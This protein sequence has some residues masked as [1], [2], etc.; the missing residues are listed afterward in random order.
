LLAQWHYLGGEVVARLVTPMESGL[1]T[2]A[3]RR[4]SGTSS[5]SAI[6]ID[7]AS[8]LLLQLNPSTST[9]HGFRVTM[10]GFTDAG[11]MTVPPITPLIAIARTSTGEFVFL[12]SQLNVL[13]PRAPATTFLTHLRLACVP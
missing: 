8:T 6:R 12:S 13:D 9:L 1:A 11:E 3:E 5:Q 10:R 2:V 7:A 4:A